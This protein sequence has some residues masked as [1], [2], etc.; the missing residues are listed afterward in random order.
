MIKPTLARLSLALLLATTACAASANDFID[1]ASAAGVGQVEASKQA[2]AKTG[3]DDVKTYANVMIKDHTIIN[4]QLAQLGQK[5]NIQVPAEA[6]LA[7]KVKP[8]KPIAGKSW[9]ASYAANQV[10]VQT[11]VAE[12]FKDEANSSDVPELKAYALEN[13]PT[14]NRHLKMAQRLLKTYKK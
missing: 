14:V 4:E 10:Q 3:Y 5:L 9:E 2:L 8:M 13:L 11:A 6:A 12:L 1:R 7:G